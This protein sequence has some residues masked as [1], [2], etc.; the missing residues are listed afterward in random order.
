MS[1][2]EEIEEDDGEDEEDQQDYG[3]VSPRVYVVKLGR[4]L[5]IDA[6]YVMAIFFAGHRQDTEIFE[7]QFVH[8]DRIKYFHG[9]F[10]PPYFL[11]RR[12]LH[13]IR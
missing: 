3:G 12:L 8:W 5:D 1:Q 9:P 13:L 4:D 11:L 2:T 10:Q 6:W 7:L